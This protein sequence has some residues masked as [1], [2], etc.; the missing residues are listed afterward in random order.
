[1][2]IAAIRADR[3]PENP[4][5]QPREGTFYSRAVYNPAVWKEDGTWWMMVRGE[6]VGDACSG[7]L[8]LASG[9]DGV[10]FEVAPEPV[11]V[12]EYPYEALGCED[13]RLVCIEGLYVLTYVGK[14]ST[15]GGGRI[16][17]A[18]SEDLQHWRKHGPVLRPR[19]GRWNEGQ[20]KAGAIAPFRVNGR[21]AMF[22]LGERRPWH[23]AI[24]L[25]Y[26]D[27]L[28]H[29]EE[30]NENLVLLPRQ[31]YFDSQGV[32]PGPPPVRTEEGILLIY[33]GWDARRVHCVGAALLDPE[34]PRQVIARTD[35]P[36]LAPTLPWERQGHVPNVV[37]ATGLVYDSAIY[38]LYYGAADHVVGLATLVLA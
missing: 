19:P 11:I 22:F 14:A 31:G 23:T 9:S 3:H 5:L 38:R 27:D 12:P 17:L 26:S 20:V 33:N 4:I 28:V 6:S 29:W 36:I 1:M 7:Y 2:N 35:E 16:C 8:G 18:T 21:Y 34:D 10:H 24:G 30:P 25:A 15:Y 37:F 13:P 32:E